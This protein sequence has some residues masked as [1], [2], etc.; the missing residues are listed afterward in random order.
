MFI[1]QITIIGKKLESSKHKSVQKKL[2][3]MV[4]MSNVNILKNKNEVLDEKI[5]TTLMR[6]WLAAT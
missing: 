4:K 6:L 5:N 3:Q 2:T 1:V